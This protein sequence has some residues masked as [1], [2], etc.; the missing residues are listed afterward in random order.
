ME[1]KRTIFYIFETT[2]QLFNNYYNGHDDN[3]T[4]E[5][6]NELLDT[7]TEL[8]EQLKDLKQAHN[9]ELKE[10]LESEEN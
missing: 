10:F 6:L 2:R 1:L 3:F 9:E 7:I 4:K 5:E 8:E